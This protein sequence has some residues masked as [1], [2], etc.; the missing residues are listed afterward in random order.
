MEWSSV[1][2]MQKEVHQVLSNALGLC[3][4]SCG[5]ELQLKER[6]V[7]GDLH[8]NVE[9]YRKKAVKAQNEEE[10]NSAF[11]NRNAI[12]AIINYLQLWLL[13]KADQ[14]EDAW[15]Q[16][17][18]GQK[19]LRLVLRFVENQGLAG[20]LRE[21]IALEH[22][23]FPPQQFVSS[24]HCIGRSSCSI[25]RKAYGDCEHLAG[26][27]YTGEMC[28][29]IVEEVSAV[30]HVA[31][32]ENPADKECRRVTVRRGEYMYSTLTLRQLGKAERD[33]DAEGIVLTAGT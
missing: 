20:C 27:L 12:L 33:Q 7:L 19:S 10:A 1:D 28:S 2:E 26:F 5:H 25:C 24:A 32:V 18:D 8:K 6:D 3:F 21:L 22:L 14:M 15:H 4:A 16:L 30:D 17:V 9:A 29:Q 11:L 23:L 31:L 13:I